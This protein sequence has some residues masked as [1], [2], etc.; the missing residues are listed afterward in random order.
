MDSNEVVRLIKEQRPGFA[1][2]GHLAARD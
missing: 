1:N 2:G